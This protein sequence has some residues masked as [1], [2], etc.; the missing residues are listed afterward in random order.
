[1]NLDY[2][3]VVV[4][5]GPGG[6]LAARHAALSGASVLMIEKRQEIGS[7]LRCA[8]GIS[9]EWLQE[10]GI[11]TDDRWVSN[12]VSGAKLVSPCGNQFYVDEKMAG[13]EVGVVLERHLFDKA[14]AADAARAG[15]EIMLKTPAVDL[16]KENGEVKGVRAMSNGEPLKITARCV[17][18]ADGFESQVGRWAGLDTS[19]KQS[20]ITS[21]FQY[22][23]TNIETESDYTEFFV[24]SA[25][26]GGY[27][28]I[29]PKDECTANV[30]LGIQLSKLREPGEVRRYLDRFIASNDRLKDGQPLEAVGGAVSVSPP[31]DRTTTDGLMLVG[32]AARMIDSITGGGIAHACLSGMY[33]GRVAGEALEADD[34]SQ[35]FLQ[36]YEE[37]WRDRLEDKLW[38]NWM[39]KEKLVT[40]TDEQFDG[41]ISTLSEVGLEKISVYNILKVVKERHPDLVEDFQEFI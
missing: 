10:A 37:L 39:A 17:V 38:R 8:E 28:W 20:D 13:N 23:L 16:I 12:S 6:S 35:E 14:M 2:D 26:P 7:P 27:V 11:R 29:F 25:A 33:A 34:F 18:G 22:R 21:C 30:G 36:R 31:L 9:R 4:G 1:M 41:V 5:A 24:G 15:A 3:V 19:L 40:V 32:D